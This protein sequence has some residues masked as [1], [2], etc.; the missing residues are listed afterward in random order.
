[1]RSSAHDLVMSGSDHR[2]PAV[3]VVMATC[4]NAGPLERAITS[5]L[6]TR[7]EPLEIIVVENRPPDAGTRRVAEERFAG[8]RIRYVE[9]PQRGAS[10]ARNRGLALAQGDIVSFTDDDVV[11]DACWVERAVAALTG[12]DDVAC[13]T[14]RILPLALATPSQVR[15]DQFAAFDKGTERRA[16]RLP[17]S[18]AADPL[19]PYLAG[20]LGSGANFFVGREVAVELG[21][22]DL[23]LGPGTPTAGGEDLDFF[24]RLAHAGLTIVYDPAVTLR[25]DHPDSPAVLRK[26]AYTYGVGLT[27][28]LGKQ[29]LHGPERLRLLR[30]I[31]AGVRYG[32]D[33]TSRKNAMKSSDFPWSLELLERLGMLLGPAAYL[34][35][36]AG[37][38]V[39][40][41]P[42]IGN[43]SRRPPRSERLSPS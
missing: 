21:G 23:L 33:R 8:E 25:H 11:V 40:G 29:L 13:V 19:F 6:D 14:G 43:L 26:R 20:H 24:I 34:V 15:F 9:E 12:P 17:E 42:M 10:R 1:M 39:R 18:R 41:M 31:P 30:A 28:M 4:A 35:S 22:F 37:S 7:Y 3:S 38:A 16:F 2:R 32:L 27:A 5:I 36:L